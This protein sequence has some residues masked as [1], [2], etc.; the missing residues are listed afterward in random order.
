MDGHNINNVNCETIRTFKK[1]KEQ[2]LK[3]KISELETSNENKNIRN[4]YK[5]KN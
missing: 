2:Y 1:C 5:V 3:D 4:L